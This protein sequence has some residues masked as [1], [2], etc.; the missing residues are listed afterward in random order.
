MSRNIT[1][2]S[3]NDRLVFLKSAPSRDY[4]EQLWHPMLSLEAIRRGDRFVTG[5]TLRILPQGARVVDA[6]CGIG[7]TVYGLANSGFDAYGIDYAQDTVA[8]IRALAPE[9]RIQVA[10]VRALPYG[11]A[12]LDGVWSL[13]VIEHFYD[14]FDPL[15]VEAHRVLRAGGY[16]FLTVPVISPLKALKIRLNVFPDYDVADLEQFFQFA[17][18]PRFVA[19]KVASHGFNLQRSYGRSGAFGLTEDAPRLARALMLRLDAESLPSRAWWRLID[20][21]ITPFSQ[22]TRYYLFQKV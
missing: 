13:G 16:L 2:D 14:G 18:R 15:I 7:A 10:D 3:L 6:G 22:H 1:Y 8:A 17:F 5:E 20:G 11:D 19:E 9:L 4:W 21:A 12:S